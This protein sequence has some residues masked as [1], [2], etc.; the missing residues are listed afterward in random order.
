MRKLKNICFGISILL[1]II[2]MPAEGQDFFQLKDQIIRDAWIKKSIF[3]IRPSI[4][5]SNLGYHSN[6]YSYDHMENPDWTGEASLELDLAVILKDRLI[7]QIK[8]S[9]S[10]SYY[11]DHDGERSFNNIFQLA[12]HTWLGQFNVHYELELPYIHAMLNPETGWRLRRWEYNHTV[13]VDYGSHRHFYLSAYFKRKD[14]S[15]K[16]ELYLDS[17]NLDQ[18]LSRTEYWVGFSINKLI[19]TRT[20]IS[21]HVDYFDHQYEFVRMRNH[22]GGQASLRLVLPAGRHITGILR[23]GIRF[24]RPLMAYHR[25]FIKPFGSGQLSIHFMERFILHADYLLANRYSFSGAEIYYDEQSAGAGLTCIITRRFRVRGIVRTGKRSYRTLG[26]GGE[27][28]RDYFSS[29]SAVVTL[30]L[31]EKAELGLQYRVYRSDSSELRFYR[32]YD[33]IGGYIRYDF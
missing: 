33:S 2:A 7:L 17:F 11:R 16:D 24:V 9:P 4:V 31:G 14:L 15:F 23:Y 21:F 30:R 20:R 26:G 18:L 32:S 27:Q 3:Y 12:A 19:F 25:D 10:Y 1:A 22:T 5:F 28:R 8:E 13:T 29:A 6:I